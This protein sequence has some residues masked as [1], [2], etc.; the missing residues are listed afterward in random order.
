MSHWLMHS[1]EHHLQLPPSIGASPLLSPGVNTIERVSSASA[2][3][4]RKGDEVDIRERCTTGDRVIECIV[5]ATNADSI[6]L[7]Q[8][9]VSGFEISRRFTSLLAC[10]NHRLDK[11][12]V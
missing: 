4:N 8:Y 12:W 7:L 2:L 10:I 3:G 5:T 11:S 1:T 6:C 9:A